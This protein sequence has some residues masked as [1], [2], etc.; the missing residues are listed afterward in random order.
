MPEAVQSWMALV[1]SG[2]LSQP[3]FA[4]HPLEGFADPYISA[5]FGGQQGY[6]FEASA[7][8][9]ICRQEVS[10]SD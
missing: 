2:G 1:L 7:K 9:T 8:K 6:D 5:F 3:A 10:L 4:D